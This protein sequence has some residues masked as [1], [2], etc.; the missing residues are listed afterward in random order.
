[1]SDCAEHEA[2]LTLALERVKR[3]E[4]ALRADARDAMHIIDST[5]P[6]IYEKDWNSEEPSDAFKTLL[7]YANLIRHRASAALRPEGT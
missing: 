4:E 1:M 5:D 2:T 3:L 6:V 7:H